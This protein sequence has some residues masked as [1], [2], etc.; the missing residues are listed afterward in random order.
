MI[1]L[2]VEECNAV[3]IA[4]AMWLA[5]RGSLV[6]VA[7]LRPAL[8]M[9]G[10][11]LRMMTVTL[12]P[13]PVIAAVPALFLLLMLMRPVLLMRLKRLRPRLRVA[14]AVGCLDRRAEQ[15]LDVA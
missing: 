5:G 1:A 10:T 12:L 4:A 2:S 9:G 8:A 11:A 6:R 13:T 14:A 15:P 7:R 3:E